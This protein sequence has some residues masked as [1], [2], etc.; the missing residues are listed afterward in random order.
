MLKKL[1]LATGVLSG[2]LVATT[3]LAAPASATVSNQDKTQYYGHMQLTTKN[4]S[5]AEQGRGQLQ[6]K[7]ALTRE[8]TSDNA[9]IKE[10]GI[11]SLAR[12]NY[13][14]VHKQ[15]DTE[16]VYVILSGT[17]LFSDGRSENIVS[18]GDIMIARVGQSCGLRNVGYEPLRF[19]MILAKNEGNPA[20]WAE[21]MNPKRIDNQHMSE[22]REDNG[23]MREAEMYAAR[24]QAQVD[25]DEK[26][27]ADKELAKANKNHSKDAAKAEEKQAKEKAKADAI[28]EKKRLELADKQRKEDAKKEEL[29]RKA[30][31]KREKARQELVQ[32][33]A[34]EAEKNARRANNSKNVK[35][36]DSGRSAAVRAARADEAEWEAARRAKIAAENA[37][38]LD[39]AFAIGKK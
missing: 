3:V 9:A 14:G 25:A 29:E 36:D 11:M 12:G 1:G 30:M 8:T 28:A 39:D 7:M 22:F 17:G 19:V 38:E 6:G 35:P 24:I 2:L 20:T 10:L 23:M 18:E 34:K 33:A 26:A 32:E 5:D 4:V 37:N 31:A 13:I 27:K 16:E 15:D 21:S